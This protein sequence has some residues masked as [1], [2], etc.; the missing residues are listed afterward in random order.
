MTGSAEER[1]AGPASVGARV[2]DWSA[3]V[4]TGVRAI[5]SKFLSDRG[6]HLAAMISYFALLAFVPL[7]VIALSLIGLVGQQDESSELIRQLR[8]TFPETSVDHLV[9]AVEGIRDRAV[10]LGIIGAF[11]LIWAALGLFSVLESA[12]NLIYGVPNRSFAHGKALML[13]AVSGSLILLFASLLASS[14]GVE[15]LERVGISTVPVRYLVAIAISTALIFG[16]ALGAYRFLPN[17]TLTWRDVWPG[18]LFATVVLQTTFQLVPI[19]VRATDSLVALQAFGGLL[20]LLV[21][22]YV[23]ANVL[24]IGAVVNWWLERGRF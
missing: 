18:A 13:L 2:A 16:L 3:F 10:S 12:F 14:L 21:W 20:L 11:F 24:V 23:M 8:Q 5:A 17:V 9:Q 1:G 7:L 15:L 6:T 4:V 22:L 19:Y